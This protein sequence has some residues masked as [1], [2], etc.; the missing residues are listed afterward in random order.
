MTANAKASTGSIVLD[1]SRMLGFDQAPQAAPSRRVRL[2][3]LGAKV[4]AKQGLKPK[5][6]P[7]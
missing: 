6:G 2:A 3:R 5:P 7:A 4:G 1:W